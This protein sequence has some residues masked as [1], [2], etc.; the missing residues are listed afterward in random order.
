MVLACLPVW[1]HTLSA[2]LSCSNKRHKRD[3]NETPRTMCKERKILSVVSSS[4][5]RIRSAGISALQMRVEAHRALLREER[6]NNRLMRRVV[7]AAVNSIA[8][9]GAEVWWRGQQDRAKHLQLL[10]KSQARAITD[11]LPSTPVSTLLLAACLPRAEELS[12]YRQRWFA[13]VRA[14][15]AP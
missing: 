11:L 2:D 5:T 7:V 10:L 14:L 3:H 6:K 4:H 8:L 13:A 15:A 12:D 9:Y 1:R